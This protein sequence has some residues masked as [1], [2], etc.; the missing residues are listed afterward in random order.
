MLP[1]HGDDPLRQPDEHAAS[2]AAQLTEGLVP[3]L[4]GPEP[5]LDERRSAM[6]PPDSD[7]AASPVRATVPGYEILSELG[8]GG[9][10][11]VYLARHVGLNRL[12]ALKMILAGGHAGP[13]DL[14]R[15]RGEAEAVARL[16]HPNVVQVYDIGEAHGQPYFSLEFVEGG[17]LDKKL[18]GTPLPPGEA[19]ALV[20]TLAQAVA[21][22]HAA[23]LV[24]RDLKPANVLL[25]ADGMLKV[26][27]F[28]LVKKLD[29]AP[30][31][32]TGV[33]MGT[34][35]YMA[36]EQAGGK[37]GMIGPATD[38]Y[39]LG[40]IL[41]ECLTGRPPFKAA[42]PLDT[43]MQVVSD[44]PVPPGQLQSRTPKDLETVCLK[45]LQKDPTRRYTSAAALA[46][47]LRRFQGGE[48][49]WARPVGRVERGWRWCRRN[50]V[51]AGLVA[52]VAGVLLLGT[53]V[54]TVLAVWALGE[55][56]RADENAVAARESE[57]QKEREASNARDAERRA[58]ERLAEATTQ[59]GRAERHLRL[60]AAALAPVNKGMDE[61]SRYEM[62]REY[63]MVQYPEDTPLEFR[64]RIEDAEQA[65]RDLPE[66]STK[67]VQLSRALALHHLKYAV[68]L[69]GDAQGR[70][71]AIQ[72][73][74]KAV[75]MLEPDC[76]KRS[77]SPSG[78]RSTVRETNDGNRVTWVVL[79]LAY[80]VR[81]DVLSLLGRH[82]DADANYREAL[83]SDTDDP[84]LRLRYADNLFALRRYDRVTAE[85]EKLLASPDK[86]MPYHFALSAA[87]S[88]AGKVAQLKADSELADRF[89][90]LALRWLRR[91]LAQG[92]SPQGI[93]NTLL[94]SDDFAV[95]RARPEYRKLIQELE[96]RPK[97]Q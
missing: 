1:S 41:Y 43:L 5:A 7:P 30:L 49:V 24:H 82:T 70:S 95:V 4:P 20:E 35:S 85:A 40:A 44:E 9:M 86:E 78:V 91:A 37:S 34:P 32:A 83:M 96:V 28:G 65:L 22:A 71:L 87:E 14:A 25:A 16:K 2:R 21:A 66:D 59:K 63:L 39:A 31:T 6:L 93:L 36:P 64:R 15:F 3:A 10:G 48:P 94:N 61:R 81:A 90:N 42:T 51:V 47:D 13:D 72:H 89:A 92:H 50:P 45:C 60:L 8:R 12:V 18:A 38:V 74:D 67:T 19:A 33:V 11:V 26:T 53:A 58:N 73:C 68:S 46:E 55:K 84:S 79:R 23:G 57:Q 62:F 52:A 69:V 56:T 54:S 76:V 27:D 29:A 88:L 97:S 17:S 80:A 77:V 75:K